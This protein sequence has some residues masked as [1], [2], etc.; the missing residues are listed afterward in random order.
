MDAG[1]KTGATVDTL[2]IGN[3]LTN[4]KSKLMA[5]FKKYSSDYHK[6]GLGAIF[7][8][9]EKLYP[10]ASSVIPVCGLL[11]YEQDG[12]V[13]GKAVI[14]SSDIG[15][16][17]K[18]FG[19]QVKTYGFAFQGCSTLN[20]AGGCLPTYYERVLACYLPRSCLGK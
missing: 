20:G 7:I 11:S 10:C 4:T 6:S 14:E 8:N 1:I 13:K 3:G 12:F 16:N 5:Y 2:P 15:N 19:T 9:L 17:L 18:V